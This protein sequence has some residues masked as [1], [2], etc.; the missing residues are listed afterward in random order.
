M[1]DIWLDFPTPKLVRSPCASPIVI[2]N[3][4]MIHTVLYFKNVPPV[5]GSKLHS[6]RSIASQASQLQRSP[7]LQWLRRIKTV[8]GE[9]VVIKQSSHTLTR[10]LFRLESQGVFFFSAPQSSVKETAKLA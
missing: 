3:F 9:G 4:E 10:P 1:V 6:S 8:K 2:I 7:S 5:T